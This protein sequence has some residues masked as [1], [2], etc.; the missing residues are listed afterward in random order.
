M[1]AMLFD[2][3]LERMEGAW[4]RDRSLRVKTDRAPAPIIH[5][6]RSPTRRISRGSKACKA[7]QFSGPFTLDLILTLTVFSTGGASYPRG[8]PHPRNGV[9]LVNDLIIK[10]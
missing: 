10:P 2:P 6:P 1:I 4:R 8:Q 7:R 5:S 9:L 3:H